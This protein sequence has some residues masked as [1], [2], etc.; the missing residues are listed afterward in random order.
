MYI[1]NFYFWRP[2]KLK[3]SFLQL[4][5]DR[6]SKL[7]NSHT[8]SFRDIKLDM[9]EQAALKVVGSE[10]HKQVVPIIIHVAEHL[11]TVTSLEGEGIICLT[12]HCSSIKRAM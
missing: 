10:S 7:L 5:L 4:F 1:S 8:S 9:A 11:H 12:Y 6:S 2:H 3:T